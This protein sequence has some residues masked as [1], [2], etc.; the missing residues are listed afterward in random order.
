VSEELDLGDLAPM[1]I[2]VKIDGKKYVLREAT[3]DAVD[4]YR[5]AETQGAE[6]T[7]SSDG[8]M[9]VR[10]T[11]DTRGADTLLVSLCLCQVNGDG[12]IRLDT[13]GDPATV[14]LRTVKGWPDRYVRPL[15]DKIREISPSLKLET[16]ADVQRRM[17]ADRMK[18]A[19]L[20]NGH[21]EDAA[22]NEQ[23]ATTDTSA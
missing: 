13:N 22:K 21:A 7:Q 16:A 14:P 10:K 15:F 4:R 20:Q 17:A 19:S 23:S 3:A 18:L 5:A 12:S 6:V 1:Q 2:P 11:G 8:Q 9:T